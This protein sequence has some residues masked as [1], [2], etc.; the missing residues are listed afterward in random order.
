MEK[1]YPKSLRV[2]LL[3]AAA[4]VLCLLP[5]HSASAVTGGTEYEG[6]TDYSFSID[7]NGFATV[8]GYSG[9]AVVITLPSYYATLEYDENDNPYYLTHK[10]NASERTFQDNDYITDIII[11]DTMIRIGDW[12][13]DN[14]SNLSS[15]TIPDTVNSI[16]DG[17]F[18][19]CS[20]L[21][22]IS[23]PDS[24]TELG[25]YAFQE[26]TS[27]ENIRLSSSL[28]TIGGS[29]FSEDI[30]LNSIT[31]PASLYEIRPWAFAGSGL[32]EIVIP[33]NVRLISDNLFNN[34]SL[35]TSAVIGNGAKASEDSLSNMFEG[36]SSLKSVVIGN[37]ITEI[38][39][40]MFKNLTN[41]E[42][43]TIGNG[44]K[45]IREGAFQNCSS[46]ESID[47][48][49]SVTA[50][51]AYAFEDDINLV[52][53]RFS[54]NLQKIGY[55][56]FW[57]CNNLASL[58]LPEGL[59]IIES[60]VFANA[61]ALKEVVLP[62][63]LKRLGSWI[64][65]YDHSL[66]K[67]TFLGDAP[68]SLEDESAID[69]PFNECPDTLVVWVPLEYRDHYAVEPWSSHIVEYLSDITDIIKSSE[70]Q[71]VGESENALFQVIAA[72]SNLS[73]TWQMSIDEGQS[74]QT[75]GYD[76]PVYKVAGTAENHCSL[77]RC[78]I[79]GADGNTVITEPVRLYVYGQSPRII[80]QPADL[81]AQAGTTA[82][83]TVDAVGPELTYQ[84]Q[85]STDQGNTWKDSSCTRNTWS[86]KVSETLTSRLVR[87][88]VTSDYGW[89]YVESD[90]AAL[91][92]QKST[93]KIKTVT[94][95]INGVKLTWN[96]ISGVKKYR[97]FYKLSGGKW[98][99]I[100][101]V[102]GS[103][104]ST[105]TYTWTTPVSGTTYTFTVRGISADGKTYTTPLDT[106]G[107]T[108]TF[109]TAPK[110][111]S[112]VNVVNGVKITWGAVNGAV[113]YRLFYKVDGGKWTQI[114]DTAS[115]SY[116]WTGAQ[117]G[118]KYTF[119]VRAVDLNGV[120]TSALNTS[121]KSVTYIEA[122]E[123]SDVYQT[124]EGVSIYWNPVEGAVKYR[125]FYKIGN[126]SWVRV[127]DTVESSIL[128]TKAK[129]GTRYTFVVRAINAA[130]TAYTSAL[131]PNGVSITVE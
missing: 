118:V 72:G 128:F 65:Q 105:Q 40:T 55:E 44:V 111:T 67:V 100:A 18:R 117:S 104:A 123:I 14:C 119:V 17:A 107:K 125:V 64:F 82:S 30:K 88:I 71:A 26:C 124:E 131:N 33:D 53:V 68:M 114:T 59:E 60:S 74:W 27:L 93:P 66:E 121:G 106:T 29:C 95:T 70:D 20:S 127:G 112:A 109:I 89:G 97:I 87:C 116:T 15:V 84:W 51:E 120:Y 79:A 25:D 11:P 48:P 23:L 2:F 126:G 39:R 122:P 80:N 49:D 81:T 94:L 115:T 78:V 98:T 77:V 3:I 113:K 21:V 110:V 76:H 83:F 13:F 108:L 92:V 58:D 31:L 9:E 75:V 101:D 129:A 8:T 52:S 32:E 86:F 12:T 45:T 73:F 54:K 99:K 85:Y 6:N 36:C 41:L 4:F 24:I 62:A 61:H 102:E 16:G 10:V 130:G 56:A 35:L 47:I 90:P 103:T 38:Y 63:S 96:T 69:E 42:S 50:I 57:N 37:N 43:V 7:S 46:L 22:S 34:C 5:H 28:V 91:T 19:W 1:F